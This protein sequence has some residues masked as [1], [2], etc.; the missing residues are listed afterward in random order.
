MRLGRD[1]MQHDDQRQPLHSGP[2]D[3]GRQGYLITAI[4][5]LVTAL[6]AATRSDWQ[7]M[8]IAALVPPLIMFPLIFALGR[9]Q[10]EARAPGRRTGSQESMDL[11]TF[12]ARTNPLMFLMFGT[13]TRRSDDTK[14]QEL[15]RSGPYGMGRLGY[16]LFLILILAPLILTL[17][18]AALT[19]QQPTHTGP[20]FP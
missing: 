17:L 15:L 10:D 13:L 4:I 8:V 12:L 6:F 9:R 3:M 1:R 2:F 7:S 16:V 20:H 11:M 5:I 19:G 18:L 14:Y